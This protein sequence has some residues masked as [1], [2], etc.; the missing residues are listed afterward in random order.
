MEW[1]DGKEIKRHH[2]LPVSHG[3][4]D[5]RWA[6]DCMTKCHSLPVGM[7]WGMI[8]ENTWQRNE[9]ASL[10][11]YW[12]WDEQ[13]L[14]RLQGKEISVTYSLLVMRWEMID[15]AQSGKGIQ[16]WHSHTVGHWMRHDRWDS[17]AINQAVSLTY[18]LLVMGRDRVDELV[19]NRN[20][21]LSLTPCGSWDKRWLMRLYSKGI[22]CHSLS[23][24]HMMR[25]DWW[26]YIARKS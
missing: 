6:W 15:E 16:Q 9:A 4:R 7:G 19:W 3:M 20:Q 24:G 18:C 12:L 17:V 13:W 21:V 22:K 10:T 25:D 26:D 5:D 1:D 14:M 23:V 2:S 8:N 11:T